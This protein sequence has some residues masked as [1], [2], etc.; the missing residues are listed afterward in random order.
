MNNETMATDCKVDI[1]TT[2]AD[3]KDLDAL[4]LLY[5]QLHDNTMP[6]KSSYLLK[7]WQSIMNDPNHHI[8]VCKK[9]GKIVSSCV[10]VII[11]NLTHNQSP[12]A[13][14]EN[15]IT[16][17]QYRKKGLATACLNYA[18]EIAKKENCYKIMLMTG[19]KQESTLRFYEK[20]GY[21]RHDKTAFI[22]WL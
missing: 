9:N 7:L 15:V 13:L 22:Q 16:D 10:V 17:E 11:R 12:Y 5:T 14:I 21:N 8:V 18:K 6:E 1:K 3:E 19:S 2:E 20:A 4:L